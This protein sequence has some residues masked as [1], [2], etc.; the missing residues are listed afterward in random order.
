MPV[1]KRE[2]GSYVVTVWY[3]GIR[4]RKV[5][6]RWT[7]KDARDYEA[8]LQ[9]QARDAAR[10]IQPQRLITDALARW[11]AEHVPSLRSARQTRNH[12]R[13]LLPFVEGRPLVEIPQV[14]AE[15]KAAM[16]GYA[17]ATINH[18]GRILRQIGNLAWREWGWLD[19]PPAIHLLP[20]TP[21]ERF[22]TVGQVETLAKACGDPGAAGYVLLAAYTGIRRG[23]LLRI[24]A[25]DVQG[26]FIEL[27]RSGKTRRLQRVPVH[28]RVAKIAARLPLGISDRQ[29]RD[30][31]KVAREETGID[32]RWHDLRHT[33]ASWLVQAGVPLHTVAEILGHTSTAVTKRYAHLAP[34]HLRDAILKIG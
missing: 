3:A 32:C 30:A 10:G 17:P 6:R 7:Y 1:H 20:E 34:E 31:W 2:N 21:R 22:L 33:C 12:A 9:R 8:K 25:H 29:L 5:D 18:L 13:R 23:H 4:H 14:W 28:P 24:T 26:G 16:R 11:L 27:D 19:K 15:V